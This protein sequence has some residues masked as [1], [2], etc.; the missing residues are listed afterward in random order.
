MSRV[1]VLGDIHGAYRALRQC[2]ER[3]KFDY[4]KDR[5]I[6]LGDVSDGWPETRQCIDELLRIKNLTYI[7]GNHD[8]WTLEW[9]LSGRIE[10]VWYAQ[11]GKATIDSYRSGI[12]AEHVKF[13]SE[14]LLYYQY[15]NK[16]FVHAG[17]DPS[18]PPD[19]QDR[20]ILLWDRSLAS[21]ALDHYDSPAEGNLFTFDEVYIGHTPIPYPKPIVSLGVWLMD[22][23]AG[24][25]GVLS[26]MNVETKE[27]FTSDPVPTL[28]P[29]VQGRKRNR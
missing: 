19:Q 7:L 14:A 3:S 27:V 8:S 16:L 23:G 17:F 11:G 12:P 26:I 25:S 10:P 21:L 20:E 29:G 4:G 24:W 22:T 1:F 13:L 9:M 5:L 28:Y 2:L 6:S 15:D 18:R